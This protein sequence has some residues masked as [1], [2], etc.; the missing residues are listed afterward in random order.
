MEKLTFTTI[1]PGQ[2]WESNDFGRPEYLWV[3]KDYTSV[4]EELEYDRVIIHTFQR[5]LLEQEE[6]MVLHFNS[7]VSDSGW[8]TYGYEDAGFVLSS[9]DPNQIMIECVFKADTIK[10]KI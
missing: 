7:F 2:F 9:K 4:P 5:D 8:Y 1:K 6:K 10:G 3:V